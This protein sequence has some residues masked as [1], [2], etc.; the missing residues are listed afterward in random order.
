[1][2]GEDGCPEGFAALPGEACISVPTQSNERVIVYFHGML[3]SPWATKA[4]WE[5]G[6][7]ARAA[8]P[9]GYTVVAL[10]GQKGLCNWSDESRQSFCWPNGLRQQELIQPIIDRLRDALAEA[11]KLARA[12]LKPPFIVGFSNGGFLVALIASD[13]RLGVSA[14]AIAHGGPVIGQGFPPWRRRP[15]LLLAANGD[16]AHYPRMKL[17]SQM[18][19]EDRWESTFSVRE[20][21]HE[22]TAD[23]MRA[24][25]DFF[26]KM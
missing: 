10:R 9:R 8:L 1:M 24:I 26:D 12:K 11:S 13:T 7:L 19:G 14:Y 17:L 3:V 23:D 15:M 16:S 25:V 2:T 6:Q 5:L 18:L 22:M 4:K 20:G 21:V